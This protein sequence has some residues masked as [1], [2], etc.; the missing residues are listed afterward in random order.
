MTLVAAPVLA[1]GFPVSSAPA[2]RRLTR[3]RAWRSADGAVIARARISGLRARP[4]SWIDRC[5]TASYIGRRFVVDRLALPPQGG[6]AL[7]AGPAIGGGKEQNKPCHGKNRRDASYPTIDWRLAVGD[8][9]VPLTA[10][11]RG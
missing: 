6:V 2:T 10:A 5:L 4:R 11:R 9:L 7:S 8:Y 1:G 3:E